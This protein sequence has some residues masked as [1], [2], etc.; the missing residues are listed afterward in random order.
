M[1]GWLWGGAVQQDPTLQVAHLHWSPKS[2]PKDTDTPPHSPRCYRVAGRK[3]Y[4][5]FMCFTV[6]DSQGCSGVRFS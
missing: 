6:L 5:I 3:D 1:S 4:E 2:S